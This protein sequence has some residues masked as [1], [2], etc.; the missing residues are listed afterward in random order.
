EG[1]TGWADTTMLHADAKHPSC[2][3]Q[4]MNWS[5]EP[6]VQGD[7]AAW[8]GS[9]GGG[10]ARGGAPPPVLVIA[11]SW[12]DAPLQLPTANNRVTVRLPNATA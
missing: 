2:A 10:G 5:L 11:V 9:V 8:F 12:Q 7:V 4:W 6:K 1:V 3:Y